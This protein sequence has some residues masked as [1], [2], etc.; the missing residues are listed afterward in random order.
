[1]PRHVSCVPC[2]GPLLMLAVIAAMLRQLR[3]D[4][5]EVLVNAMLTILG[6]LLPRPEPATDARLRTAFGE[7]DRDLEAILGD[8]TRRS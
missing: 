8:R 6:Y 1:M 7:F 5:R 3:L 2:L 4:L